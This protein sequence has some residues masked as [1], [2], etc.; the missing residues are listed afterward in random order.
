MIS[1][2]GHDE[3]N[4][5]SGGKAGDQTGGEWAVIDWYN[6]PWNCV[7]RHPDPKV[8]AEIAKLARAAAENDLIGYDQGDRYTFWQHLEASS[9]DPMKITVACEVDCS[10]GVAAIVKAVG[11]RLN[12]DELKKVSIYD[13]T[14]NLRA[15]LKNHGFEV[16]VA[17]KYLTSAVYLLSG[18]ILLLES[19]HT[20][21]NLTDGSKS[22]AGSS[23]SGS[24]SAATGNVAKGQ[25]WLNSNYGSLIKKYCGALLEV[26]DSYGTK[27]RQ[28]A[29]TVWKDVVNR[30][31][32]K[33]LTLG[34]FNF[35]DTCKAAAKSAE[36]KK[37]SSGTL[38]Y[39]IE[40]ILAA[41]GYYSGAMDASFG[42]GLQSDVKAFQKAKG[43]S[44]D[45]IVGPDTWYAL[46]N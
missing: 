33:K 19:H 40:F 3:R 8:R 1:N 38:P 46:F 28:A 13:Y 7:L 5:Y 24:T 36:M 45:G 41:K 16:L 4:K 29:V 11:Y 39:I 25:K 18:D 12:I 6:R 44:A 23:S 37:G 35:Y 26:D 10:A 2:C 32:G 30:K 15:D 27:S 31:Y 34:N 9:Y 43:L 22:G 21:V 14:G 42:S 17:S 20:A